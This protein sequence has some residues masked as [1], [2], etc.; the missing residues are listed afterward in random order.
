LA[1]GRGYSDATLADFDFD[2]IAPLAARA[3]DQ[4]RA[5]IGF[6][7]VRGIDARAVTLEESEVIVWLLG[8]HLGPAGQPECGG[9]PGLPCRRQ[10]RRQG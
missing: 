8:Q 6:A 3:L 1:A 2:G 7:V 4:I 10:G 9:R 5:G